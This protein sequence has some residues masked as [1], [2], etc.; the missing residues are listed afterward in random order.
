MH[1]DGWIDDIE[2]IESEVIK[3]ARDPGGRDNPLPRRGKC[4]DVDGPCIGWS[5]CGCGRFLTLREL[6]KRRSESAPPALSDGR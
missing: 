3:Y 5:A 1:P 2:E 6:R 4:N